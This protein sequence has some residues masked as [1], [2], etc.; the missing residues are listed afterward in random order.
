LHV[1]GRGTPSLSR[2]HASVQHRVQFQIPTTPTYLFFHLRLILSMFLVCPAFFSYVF[3]VVTVV[4]MCCKRK[5]ISRGERTTRLPIKDI[6]VTLKAQIVEKV[7]LGLF[8]DADCRFPPCSATYMSSVGW[9]FVPHQIPAQPSYQ[10]SHWATPFLNESIQEKSTLSKNSIQKTFQCL[11]TEIHFHIA[12]HLP[13]HAIVLL[14]HSN[15]LTE[16]IRQAYN[17]ADPR[18]KRSEVRNLSY[19]S[20]RIWRELRTRDVFERTPYP[21]EITGFSESA[22]EI[23][24]IWEASN[25]YCFCCKESV[26]L[27]HFPI[28]QMLESVSNRTG[29]NKITDR[30]CFAHLTPVQLWANRLVTWERLQEAREELRL[31]DVWKLLHWDFNHT[32]KSLRAGKHKRPLSPPNTLILHRILPD[33]V[34]AKA[35]Y[36][37]DLYKPLRFRAANTST[38]VNLVKE[39]PPYICPHLDLA[40]LFDQLMAYKPIIFHPQMRTHDPALTVAEALVR[41]MER[42]TWSTDPDAFPQGSQ[43][44]VKEQAIWC[45]FKEDGCRTRVSLQRFRDRERWTV[46]WMRDLVRLKVVRQWRVDR[47]TGGAEWQAQNGVSVKA[48][49]VV[50]MKG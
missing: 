30:K 47:G 40:R 15:E 46:G 31:P 2:A 26:G 16:G 41:A 48:K 12:A 50:G 29:M 45:G 24:E 1:L 19:E 27:A 39:N 34:E 9:L 23:W 22:R 28:K 36:F 7:D 42:K 4:L 43:C 37:V 49:Y 35:K 11:P 20:V 44:K 6:P 25:F 32:T 33:E 21:L 8:K 3:V 38:I 18:G 5:P 13:D 14:A 17:K 10:T